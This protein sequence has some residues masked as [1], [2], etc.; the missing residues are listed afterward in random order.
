[1]PGL[2]SQDVFG[3]IAY[4]RLAA[5]YQLNPYVWPPS[6]LLNDHA[7]AWVADVWRDYAT[8]YGPLWVSVQ[9]LLA[10]TTSSLSIADQALVYRGLA[11]VLL[12]VNLGLA[13]RLT[14]QLTRTQRVVILTALAWNPLL[15]FEGAGNAHSDVL[16]VTFCLGALLLF[17]T[18]GRGVLACATL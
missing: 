15:L 17:R 2:F 8:P 10:R 18:S 16:M 3:Y 12:L 4:G 11:S 9:W 13:W 1:M 7:L 14:G 5:V 6:V